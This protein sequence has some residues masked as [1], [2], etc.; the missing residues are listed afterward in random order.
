MIYVTHD[1]VE[2]MT[3]AD[4]IVVLSAGQI[5]QVG[6]PRDLYDHPA[7]LFVAQFIGSPKMNIIPCTTVAENFK[8]DGHG[9]QLPAAHHRSQG[10]EAWHSPGAYS[11]WRSG[12]RAHEGPRRCGRVSG[13][14]HLS[15]RD[16]EGH[17]T[18]I[19]RVAGTETV[20]VGD[21]VALVFEKD[22]ICFFDEDGQAIR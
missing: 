7:N 3:L 11:A 6:S 12:L 18:M 21:E 20:K 19:V 22:F 10:G 16:A 9:G 1:Q 8:I 13:R 5:E 15:L 14:R 17:E 2:A 4:K